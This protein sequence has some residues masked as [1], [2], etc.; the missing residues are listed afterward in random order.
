MLLSRKNL[1]NPFKN[2]FLRFLSSHSFLPSNDTILVIENINLYY[3]PV[4]DPITAIIFFII[5]ALLFIIGVYLHLKLLDM[6]KRENGLLNNVTKTFVIANIILWSVVGSSI[7]I[8]NLVH[9][10]PNFIT[11]WLCPTI[12]F[13]N[14]M[15]GN[16]ILTHSFICASLRYAFIVHTDRVNSFGRERMKKL[17][18]ILFLLISI[19]VTLWKAIDGADLDSLSYIN[20][21]YRKHH[22]VFLVETSTLNVFKKNF[23]EMTGGLPEMEGFPYFIALIKQIGCMASMAT[24]LVSG[25]NLTEGFIYCRLFIYMHR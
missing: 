22:D 2:S 19:F 16:M 10:L 12:W 4:P 23:C 14:Y 1:Y 24:I 13:L 8:T 25:S 7:T 21:C 15:A 20:K 6:L 11:Q 17:F 9:S 5:M 18:L 3:Q